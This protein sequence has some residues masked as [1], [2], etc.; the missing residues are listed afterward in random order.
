MALELRPPPLSAPCPGPAA[1]SAAGPELPLAL[2]CAWPS[3]SSSA[4]D[5]SE[6]RAP[7][8]S[9]KLASSGGSGV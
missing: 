4:G 6:P 8:R 1:S 2:G 3:A 7:S 9:T 5:R